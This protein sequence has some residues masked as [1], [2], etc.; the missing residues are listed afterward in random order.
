MKLLNNLIE[1]ITNNKIYILLSLIQII[2]IITNP[3]NLINKHP[4]LNNILILINMFY[5]IIILILSRYLG[6]NNLS[7]YPFKILNIILF[8]ITIIIIPIL[9]LTQVKVLYGILKFIKFI[10][11]LVIILVI[12][13]SFIYIL[14]GSNET[15]NK[16]MNILMN[17]IINEYNNIE[18]PLK[19]LFF[20]ELITLLIMY[21]LPYIYDKYLSI[22]GIYI[23][24]NKIYLNN[25]KIFNNYE[26]E[27]QK[28]NH[29]YS[30]SFSLW[31]NPQPSNTS[32]SYSKYT[33]LLNYG[34]K[35]I[36]E[37]NGNKQ[38]FRIR[39]DV[40]E[41]NIKTIYK[42]N[43]FKYQKWNRIVINYDGGNMDV[44]I[45]GILVAS[46]MNVA[47]YMKND[48]LISGETN[49]IHGG[50]NNIIYFDR[51]LLKNE[52]INQNKIMY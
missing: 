11:I 35:P 2:F 38:I 41:N 51:I 27:K 25:K 14:K 46:E 28:L 1:F 43:N 29:K 39:T 42:T 21:V 13:L 3:S 26:L 50:I 16:I 20:I 45:N 31:I 22:N 36:I 15:I 49:G 7:N 34:N 19:L 10:F 24:K 18:K 4:Y 48:K 5:I 12:I 40:G 33:N 8:V 37:Y 30:L 44:F 52:I 23:L 9:L 17:K 32:V 47:P 6:I